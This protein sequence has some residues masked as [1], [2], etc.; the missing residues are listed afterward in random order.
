MD[1][2]GRRGIDLPDVHGRD[3]HGRLVL[4][5]IPGELAI[6]RAPLDVDVVHAVGEL[7]RSIHDASV[8]LP[9]PD[10]WDVLLPVEQPELLCH[11]DL[12][13][14]NLIIDGD[15]LVFIDWDGA[16]PS[17]RLWDLAYAA[18]SFGHLFPEEQP[19]SAAERLAAFVDGY[20]ADHA[21]RSALPATMA[22]RAAAMYELLKR[23]H[24]GGREPR[25]S[26]YA[27]DH[28]QHWLGTKEF[29]SEHQRDWRR[30]LSPT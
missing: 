17:T 1:A 20:G 3:D 5:L 24:E 18:I 19:G 27:D 2:L 10:D 13:T 9:F 23:S 16:G 14:W 4:E 29:I 30:A 22:E 21:L 28:G 6:D 15:R 12:A 8:G 11:N 7:V 26:M 25:G